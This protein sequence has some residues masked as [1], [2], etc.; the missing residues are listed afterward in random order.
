MSTREHCD[1]SAL[2][3][4]AFPGRSDIQISKILT[5][6][7][8]DEIRAVVTS[9]SSVVLTAVGRPNG[10]TVIVTGEP[11]SISTDSVIFKGFWDEVSKI[12]GE[13]VGGLLGGDGKGGSQKCTTTTT[14]QVGSGG[15]VESITTTTTCSPA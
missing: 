5:T 7:K 15:K 12:I 3:F 10:D 11:G 9:G 14:V 8:G 6:A 4:E 2:E 13:I 1:E